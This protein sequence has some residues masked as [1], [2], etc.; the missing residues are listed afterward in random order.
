[1]IWQS[2]IGVLTVR[3]NNKEKECERIKKNLRDL[4]DKYEVTVRNI[5]IEYE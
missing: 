2:E 1:M 5:K 4:E 3:L